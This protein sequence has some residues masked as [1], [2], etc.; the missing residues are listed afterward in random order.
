MS[1]E[2]QWSAPSVSNGRSLPRRGAAAALAAQLAAP[3]C[4]NSREARGGLVPPPMP[5]PNAQHACLPSSVPPWRVPAAQRGMPAGRHPYPHYPEEQPGPP[6]SDVPAPTPGFWSSG[7]PTSGSGRP[8]P[9][10]S[11]H[12]VGAVADEPV[13]D[14][15]SED[16]DRELLGNSE[17]AE[18]GS[19]A[20]PT[21]G[22]R[23]H[24]ARMCKPCAF[25]LKGCQSGMDCKF[26]H[27]CEVGEKKR[28][29]KEKVAIRREMQ[30]WRQAPRQS[31]SSPSTPTGQTHTT[32]SLK[33]W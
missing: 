20:C 7:S 2:V 24:S 26:C 22:S 30:R 29:K 18:L 21:L 12:L 3:N 28:R 31:Y 5:P 23:G 6:P 15:S 13:E 10:S 19:P 33:F 32:R 27:L 9:S 4:G 16:G 14:E 11:G 17:C 25:V 8:R 1:P